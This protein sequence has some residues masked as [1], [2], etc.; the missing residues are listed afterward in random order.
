MK[1][2]ILSF[3]NVVSHGASL[4]MY[5]LN[6]ILISLGCEV[7]I[8]NF[9]SE[10]GIKFKIINSNSVSYI[11]LL[12]KFVTDLIVKSPKEAFRKFE[13][14]MVLYP[15]R[16][17]TFQTCQSDMTGLLSAAIRYGIHTLREQHTVFIWI[18]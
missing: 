11:Q 12:K 17:I 16:M 10:D 3:P 8:I 15:T 9:C 6:Y 18:L 2:G 13:K 1:V 4:Q 14:Q 7:E 5:A